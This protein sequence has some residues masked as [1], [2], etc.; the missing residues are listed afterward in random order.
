M[1]AGLSF[2]DG[3]G[4]EKVVRDVISRAKRIDP[5]FEL[6][7]SF[8]FFLEALMLTIKQRSLFVEALFCLV[9]WGLPFF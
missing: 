4:F 3:K 7:E 6:L 1:K 9:V 5:R 2:E 8:D